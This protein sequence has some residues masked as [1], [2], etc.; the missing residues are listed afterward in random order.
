MEIGDSM[1]TIVAGTGHRPQFAE[2]GKLKAFSEA[3]GIAM[4]QT[5]RH[6]L[7]Q[8]GAE[9]VISG[10]ALGWDTALARAAYSLKIPYA[11]Y[12]PCYGFGSQWNEAQQSTFR[13]M[14]K[15]AAHWRTVTE[16]PYASNLMVIR[17]HAMVNDANTVLALWNGQEHGGTWHT[18]KYA[19]SKDIK[20]VNAWEY[21]KSLG[22]S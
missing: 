5:A 1:K 19:E 4:M 16:K 13:N 7:Q 18:V 20:V 10:G 15:H 17:D 14:L 9:Y 6:F 12:V 22:E 3:Q 21:Y 11:V 8:L 2:I